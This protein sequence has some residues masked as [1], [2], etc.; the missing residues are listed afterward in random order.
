MD[1]QDKLERSIVRALIWELEQSG[2]SPVAVW[3]GEDYVSTLAADA[4][5]ASIFS[6]DTS[7]LHFA[8]KDDIN[9]WGNLGVMLVCGNG[10]DIISDYHCGNE[11]F[12]KAV[13]RV[14]DRIER[15]TVTV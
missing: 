2:F 5:I 3:D 10:K 11:Y 13:E 8:P 14:S 12:T 4:A 9:K 1:I 6:V 15:L 7:T